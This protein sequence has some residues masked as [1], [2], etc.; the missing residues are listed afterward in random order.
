MRILISLM[1]LLLSTPAFAWDSSNVPHLWTGVAMGVAA[2][3][4]LYHYAENMGTTKRT[5]VASGI[6]LFPGFVNEVVDEF[7]AAGG[8]FGWDDMAADAI[9]AV[10]G[11]F[12]SELV[13][14]Q[15]WISA[16]GN[17]I[18]LVGKW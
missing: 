15:F 9:G 4:V 8:H 16:S 12:L 10:S 7:R 11:S 13:N 5:M 18:K 1:L 6:A 2:D 14:G 3:T 17:Q